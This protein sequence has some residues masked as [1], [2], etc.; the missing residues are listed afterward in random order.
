MT[1]PTQ[2]VPNADEFLLGKSEGKSKSLKTVGEFIE[3]TVVNTDV[4]HKTKF[5]T[6]DKEY[7]DD[8]K[9]VLQYM[10]AIQT[11]ERDPE[12]EDDKG[13][14]RFYCSSEAKKAIAA[15]VKAQG[16]KGLPVGAHIRITHTG[17]EPSKGGG[18]PKKLYSAVVSVLDTPQEPAVAAAQ[19]ATPQ[20]ATTV[21]NG[22]VH[23]VQQTP[24]LQAL[25]AQVQALQAAAQQQQ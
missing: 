6:T 8:G 20:P 14:R 1:N 13:I 7:Y 11:A 15:A 17:T 16:L 9:P 22:T 5:G 10:V 18:S 24:E 4:V 25:L 3:G 23:S 2:Q 12:I 21:A 19:P